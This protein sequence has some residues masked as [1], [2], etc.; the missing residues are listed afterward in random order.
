MFR[1]LLPKRVDNSYSGHRLALWLYGFV[2]LV[3]IAIGA[4]TLYNGRTAAADADGIPLHAFTPEG[5]QAFLSVFAALGLSHLV[6]NGIAVLVLL[7]YRALVPFMFSV[8]LLEHVLRRVVFI[9]LPIPRTGTSAGF[10]INMALIVVMVVGLV[11]ALWQRGVQ[12]R[13]GAPEVCLTKV[14]TDGR[15]IDGGRSAAA[16]LERPQHD[17]SLAVLRR[18]YAEHILRVCLISPTSSRPSKGSSGTPGTPTRTS[19]AMA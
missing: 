19:S 2:V 3:K 11:L 5:A 18:V 4:G 14:G 8:L 1:Q 12:E 6:L 16:L 9:V 15:T 17:W 10:S 7:R 13:V